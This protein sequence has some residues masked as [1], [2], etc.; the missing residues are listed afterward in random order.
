M[1]QFLARVFAVL[2]KLGLDVRLNEAAPIPS[3]R[4]NVHRRDTAMRI[5]R[6]V[7]RGADYEHV[8]AWIKR[9][10]RLTCLEMRI[11]GNLLCRAKRT[12]HNA[13]D[14]RALSLT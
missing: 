6:D 13:E 10:G 8:R 7:M 2:R 5:S 1:T 12:A 9:D 11:P 4:D 3:I 14:L